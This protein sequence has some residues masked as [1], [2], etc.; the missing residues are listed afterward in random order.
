MTKNWWIKFEWNHWL[1]DPD[2]SRCSLETQGF[3]ILCLCKMHQSER[4]TLVGTIDELR[5]LFGI[6]PE[7]LTR[8]LQDLKRNNAANVIFGNGDVSV[9][10]RRYER[11][12]KAKEYNRLQ[13]RKSRS[14]SDVSS[15]SQHIV[16]SK[17][18]EI[19]KEKKKKAT[20]TTETSDQEWLDSL[21]NNPAYKLLDLKNEYA[22][23][24]VWAET[25]NRQCTRRFFVGWI[26][27]AKPMVVA[28]NGHKVGAERKAVPIVIEPP[29]DICGKEF[30]FLLHR[31]ERGI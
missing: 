19:R 4:A 30:C 22:R 17:S 27:R 2:L 29:C 8:C 24:T 20:T 31:E 10:S 14:K 13:V 12:L 25:N 7:E 6:L 28:T 18:L 16:K 23:A 15:E 26:N 5:R 9:T 1:G 3:W 11:E 21:Q